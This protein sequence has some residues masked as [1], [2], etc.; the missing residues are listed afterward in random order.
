MLDVSIE[1]RPCPGT[2]SGFADIMSSATGGKRSVPYMVDNNPSMYRYSLLSMKFI[3]YYKVVF[4]KRSGLNYLGL[5]K[6]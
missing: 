3:A 1:F 5:L 4:E 6:S 2:T